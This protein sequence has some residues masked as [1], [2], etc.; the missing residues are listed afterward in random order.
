MA[1]WNSKPCG[2]S[3]VDFESI[4]I[5]IERTNTFADRIAQKLFKKLCYPKWQQLLDP[6]TFFYPLEERY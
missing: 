3:V 1:W 6:E 2:Q 4:N 5:E